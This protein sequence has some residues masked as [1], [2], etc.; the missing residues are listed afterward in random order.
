MSILIMLN[1]FFHDFSV[2]LLFVSLF[3]LSY[4]HRMNL[5]DQSIESVRNFIGIYNYFRKTIWI[6]WI[7]IIVGGIIRTMAYEEYEW[8]PAA[9]RGQIAAL[10]VKHILLVSLVIWGSIIQTHLKRLV[11]ELTLEEK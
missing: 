7:W 2:A 9:G 1:N 6:A 8:L 4:I 11:K 5:K 10:V 3:S